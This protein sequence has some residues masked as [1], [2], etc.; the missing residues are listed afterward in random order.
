MRSLR[1]RWT[2]GL[3]S[4]LGSSALLLGLAS[5]PAAAATV[6]QTF[7]ATGALQTFTV[8]GNVCQLS[9]VVT[10]GSGGRTTAVPG[11]LGATVRSRLSVTPG[12]VLDIVV[13]GGGGSTAV[14]TGA[15]ADGGDGGFGGGGGGGVEAAAGG[16]GASSI[17]DATGP[18][19]IAG[20]GG[21]AG[22]PTPGGNA[23]VVGADAQ[24]GAGT[25]G[26]PGGGGGT[27]T[28]NGGGASDE[29][30]AAIFSSGGGGGVNLGGVSDQGGGG[31]NGLG[32]FGGGGGASS[33]LG[34]PIP[35][36]LA[37]GHDAAADQTGVAGHSNLAFNNAIGGDG[38][39]GTTGGGDGADAASF[40]GGGGGGGAGFGGGGGG[41]FGGGGG[42]G[43]GAGG[44]GWGGGGG[45]GSSWVG[46]RAS[47][48]SSSLASS[49]GAGHVSLSYE[50]S[51]DA[52]SVLLPGSGIVTAPVSGTADLAV[53]VA[54]STPSPVPVTAHW[55]TVFVPGA[56]ASAYLGP[57]APT[58]DY[59]PASGV[60]TFAP[61]QTTATVHITVTGGAFA[62]DEYIL[63]SF[64]A[65]TNARVGGFWGL[66]FGVILAP[67]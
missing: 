17:F 42:G 64:T 29:R 4:L 40:G 47:H 65:P 15:Y 7:T 25:P 9:L 11:G 51:E 27:A 38:G 63:V 45:G 59:V 37:P 50:P 26:F 18:L 32:G 31:G 48:V 49:S 52:C 53:S 67:S 12:A 66:A 61:G 5:M 33:T 21:G 39:A 62:P 28:G 30:F 10:G 19:L 22:Y 43:Y 54:L 35:P 16:G 41:L 34:N 57:E 46:T 20:G 3:G 58:S 23:G 60:V 14:P 6:T 56:A 13:G 24:A 44:G 2:L 1:S 36:A 55:T 8:P